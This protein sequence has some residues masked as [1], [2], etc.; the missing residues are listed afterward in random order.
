MLALNG[1]ETW[2]LE[3]SQRAVDTANSNVTSQLVNPSIYNFGNGEMPLKS[4]PAH[5]ILGDFFERDWE[6]QIGPTFEGFDVIYDYTVGH[7]F[8]LQAL[9]LIMYR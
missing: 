9:L 2:G 5:V 4:A 1:F 3:I 8:L 7:L 6:S